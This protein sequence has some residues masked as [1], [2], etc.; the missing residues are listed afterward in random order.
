VDSVEAGEDAG[1]DPRFITDFAF[2]I[3]PGK[4]FNTQIPV[5]IRARDLAGFEVTRDTY[6]TVIQ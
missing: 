6:V 3:G 1:L 2:L 4:T 5:Q